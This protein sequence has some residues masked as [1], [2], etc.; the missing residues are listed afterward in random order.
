M[1]LS[2]HA[3][4]IRAEWDGL[5]EHDAVFLVTLRYPVPHDAD[6]AAW[7]EE[8]QARRAAAAQAAAAGPA[9]AADDAGAADEED[10]AGGG[11]RLQLDDAPAAPAPAPAQQQS[12][13][14]GQQRGGN[15]RRGAVPDEDDPTFPARFGVVSVRG[16]E[17]VEVRDERGD[18]FNDPHAKPEDRNRRPAGY[19][20]TYKLA[21]DP[22]QY[23][24]DMLAATAAAGSGGKAAVAGEGAPLD[25][26]VYGTFNLLVRRRGEANNFK[27]V[28]AT[29]R[30][31][32][33]ELEWGH[34]VFIPKSVQ[35]ARTHRSGTPLTH[36]PSAPSTLHPRSDE[37]GS[38]RVGW[39]Q[40]GRRAAAVA[41]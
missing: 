18:V 20:R 26:G 33:W 32:A 14:G 6:P 10:G 24:A 16:G 39:R 27:A 13:R 11:S 35:P 9:A 8:E 28:L 30:D 37:R 36:S 38:V 7:W 15:A 23:H 40:S 41:A 4:F 22:A 31:G 12:Q 1:D 2:R 19:G 29:I 5:R 21:L 17:I 25:A 3:P 34:R